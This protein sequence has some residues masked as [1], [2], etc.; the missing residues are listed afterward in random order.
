[1]KI[2]L[3][4]FSFSIYSQSLD[5][6]VK[7]AQYSGSQKSM[8]SEKKLDCSH[9][10]KDF[11]NG[12]NISLSIDKKS[13]A[14]GFKNILFF[15]NEKSMKFIISGD[16]TKLDNILAIDIDEEDKK[17]YVLN[18][19][20]LG[21]QIYSYMFNQSGNH[22]PLRKFESEDLAEAV[23]IE[24]VKNKILVKQ[25]NG[26]IHVYNKEAD[27]NGRRPQYSTKRLKIIKNDV[28]SGT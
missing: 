20:T 28:N 3:L 10:F 27:I 25:S 13:K 26:D 17:I 2:L 1:M 8:P 9:L 22:T 7:N 18:Y 5:D 12:K 6:C 23:D 4:L 15:E 14:Y 16:Q 24:I 21:K 11:E 19:N